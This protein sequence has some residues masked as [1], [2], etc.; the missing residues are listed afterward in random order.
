MTLR[1]INDAAETLRDH[2]RILAHEIDLAALE[3]DAGYALAVAFDSVTTAA[4]HLL[5][6]VAGSWPTSADPDTLLGTPTPDD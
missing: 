3:S 2:L 6:A 1:Q 4:G 5:N